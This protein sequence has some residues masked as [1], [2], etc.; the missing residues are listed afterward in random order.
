MEWESFILS[1]VFDI[2]S[3]NSGI[4]KN[5]IKNID[6]EGYNPYITR[7]DKNNG[8][9]DFIIDQDYALNEGN[10][11][12]IGL[13]TQTVFYQPHSFYTG[14]NIQILSNKYLN[15]YVGLYF[16]NLLKILL[17]K[18]NWGG[19]GATLTRLKNSRILLPVND[20]GVPDYDFMEE[21]MKNIK[22]EQIDKYKKYIGELESGISCNVNEKLNNSEWKEF[23]ITDIGTVKSGKDITQKEMIPGDTPYISATSLNNG[24]KDFIKNTNNT[25]ESDCISINRNGG[26]GYAFYHPYSALFSNDCRKLIIDKDKYVSLFIA[27]QIK[28]QKEKYNYSYKMGTN[29]I[30]RQKIMLLVND[31]GEPDYEFMSDYMRNLEKELLEK[32]L[33]FVSTV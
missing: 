9:D 23:F 24:V 12:T 27:N 8:I 13:D 30:K 5:K 28:L 26:V 7:T 29:R 18:F 22:K 15:K 21:Y 17:E 3:T 10:V 6:V 1:E 2:S 31:D 4:D 32:Y 16:V 14:Q 33:D 19:N 20:V 11:I 25:L